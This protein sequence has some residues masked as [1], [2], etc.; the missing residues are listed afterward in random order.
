MSY[1]TTYDAST[2]RY[3]KV[4]VED[5]PIV[6][7]RPLPTIIADKLTELSAYCDSAIIQGITMTTE[8]GVERHFKCTTDDKIMVA[9]ALDMVKSGAP[10]Y[11][12]KDGDGVCFYAT[13]KDV[14]SIMTGFVQ[15]VTKTQTY[16]S[17]LSEYVKTLTDPQEVLSVQWGQPLTGQW[18]EEYN[19]KMGLL[20][21][22]IESMGGG[23]D[24]GG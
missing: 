7:P 5:E 10:G 23:G 16:L 17:I 11:L 3:G 4:W 13:A 19:T 1:Q 24:A 21:P 22:I 18:L 14:R 2:G 12:Y 20:T 9:A 8:D 15:H 6:D